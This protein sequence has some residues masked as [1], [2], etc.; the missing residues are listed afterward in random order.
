MLKEKSVVLNGNNI[1]QYFCLYFIVV[2]INVLVSV[3][4]F[5]P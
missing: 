4:E 3:R 5:Q 2:Q 1:S